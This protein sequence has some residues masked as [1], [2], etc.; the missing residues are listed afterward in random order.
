MRFQQL[1]NDRPWRV[2]DQRLSSVGIPGTYEFP[3]QRPQCTI[4]EVCVKQEQVAQA[5]C[6]SD[7]TGVGGSEQSR[8][9][10]AH[11][12]NDGHEPQAGV[13]VGKRGEVVESEDRLA[14]DQPEVAV[15]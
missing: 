2:R 15:L 5:D 8:P 14:S 1:V 12:K 10:T 4:R 9:E 13:G 3:G 7:R 11:R 6:C